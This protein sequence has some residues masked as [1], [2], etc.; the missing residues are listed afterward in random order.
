MDDRP[1][2]ACPDC[3]GELDLTFALEGSWVTCPVCGA[4]WIVES[5]DPPELGEG[6]ESAD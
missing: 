2:T 3:G 6:G 4:D 1:I 5:L